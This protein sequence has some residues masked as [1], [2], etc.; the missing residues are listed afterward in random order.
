MLD[1]PSAEAI[2]GLEGY[3]LSPQQRAVW[4]AQQAGGDPFER[5]AC[6]YSRVI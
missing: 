2:E 1:T 4:L 5:N 6:L 3:R